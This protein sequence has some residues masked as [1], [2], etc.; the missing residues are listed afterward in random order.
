LLEHILAGGPLLAGEVVEYSYYILWRLL[1]VNNNIS[2]HQH[3]SHHNQFRFTSELSEKED[4]NVGRV[5]DPN[6]K[7]SFNY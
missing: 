3:Y 2:N 1:R 5:V 4:E 6:V 7:V